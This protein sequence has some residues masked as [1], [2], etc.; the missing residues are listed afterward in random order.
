MKPY[1]GT[2]CSWTRPYNK[3]HYGDYLLKILF[4]S[5]LHGSLPRT[6][7][8]LAVAKEQ[9][10][11]SIALLGDALY[12]GPRNPLPEGYDPKQ[13]AQLLNQWKHRIIAVRGNCDGEVDQMLLEFPIMAD[14]SWILTDGHRMFLTHGHLWHPDSLPHLV[15]GDVFV[16]GHVHYPIAEEQNGIHIWNPGTVSLPK[17]GAQPGYGI[18]DS[19]V[20]TAYTL[21]HAPVI[22]DKLY[23]PK[24]YQ[25][26]KTA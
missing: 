19:G 14:F 1:T 25:K 15:P 13:V 7:R 3:N 11:D 4:I 9:N 20:F 24:L 5:D 21:D 16:Y 18:Y 10:V 22:Q 8:A 2:T 6:E 12:H 17:Q 23:P 26:Q